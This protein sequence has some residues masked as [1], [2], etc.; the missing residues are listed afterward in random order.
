MN[1]NGRVDSTGSDVSLT[2]VD[3]TG[4]KL[5]HGSDTRKW[6]KLEFFQMT[7][8]ITLHLLNRKHESSHDE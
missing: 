5:R 1:W 7:V 4:E 2:Q 6:K 3:L 8:S